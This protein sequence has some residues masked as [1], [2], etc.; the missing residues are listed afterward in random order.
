MKLNTGN[1]KM[2]LL[3]IEE[4]LKNTERDIQYLQVITQALNAFIRE[5]DG[6]DRSSFRIDVMKYESLLSEAY[7]L[8]R[9]INLAKEK[10]NGDK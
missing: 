6:E 2:T 4:D 5:S 3:E 1:N 9:R 8:K 7:D 10:F